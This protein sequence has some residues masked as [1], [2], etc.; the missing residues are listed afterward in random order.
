[1]LYEGSG[2]SVIGFTLSGRGLFA[3]PRTWRCPG[4]RSWDVVGTPSIASDQA[5]KNNRIVASHDIGERNVLGARLVT[6]T[7]VDLGAVVDVIV[8]A[9]DVADVVGYEVRP[10]PHSAAMHATS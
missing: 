6:D 1:M 10:Q 3:G 2:G 9:A 7:G 4:A 8:E 5:C